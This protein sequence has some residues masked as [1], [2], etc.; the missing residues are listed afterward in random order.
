VSQSHLTLAFSLK[1]PADAKAL[2]EELPPMMPELFKAEDAIGTVHYSR[3]TVLSDKTLLFLADFDGE[4]GRLMLDLADHAGPVFDTIFGHVDK[5][6]PT[7]VA[8]NAEAF[9]EWAAE[10]L[11]HPLTVYKAYSGVTASVPAVTDR[12]YD[13][14]SSRIVGCAE[15]TPAQSMACTMSG[16]YDELQSMRGRDMELYTA[17]TGNGQRAAIAVNGYR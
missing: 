15:R 16:R 12:E 17:G 4:F 1:S 2:A 13:R 6:P 7:P 8:D 14:S 5:P 9:V 10:H 11:L 3:F